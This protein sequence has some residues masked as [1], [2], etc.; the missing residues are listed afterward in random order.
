MVDMII[1]LN[2]VAALYGLL[3]CYICIVL[4][5]KY[6]LWFTVHRMCILHDSRRMFML[7]AYS[8]ASLLLYAC[9]RVASVSTAIVKSD[10]GSLDVW[11]QNVLAWFGTCLFYGLMLALLLLLARRLNEVR[12]QTLRRLWAVGTLLFSGGSFLGVVVRSD[13]SLSTEF[14]E[15]AVFVSHWWVD[16]WWMLVSVLY[17]CF[18]GKNLDRIRQLENSKYGDGVAVWRSY[19]LALSMGGTAFLTF[20]AH[21]LALGYAGMCGYPASAISVSV[22]RDVCPEIVSEVSAIVL[23]VVLEI[24][25]CVVILATKFVGLKWLTAHRTDEPLSPMY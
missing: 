3:G 1:H 5:S 22:S 10:S 8:S 14:R 13:A 25:P 9:V 21:T 15:T 4:S 7:G 17:T 11:S 12:A 23:I 24:V 16:G 6:V 2:N 18:L 20:V 19:R